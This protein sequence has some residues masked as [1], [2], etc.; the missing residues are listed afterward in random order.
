MRFPFHASHRR[1]ILKPP[2]TYQDE[3]ESE[4]HQRA[5]VG[6]VQIRSQKHRLSI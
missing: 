5:H 2:P 3:P 4:T 6:S 1:G